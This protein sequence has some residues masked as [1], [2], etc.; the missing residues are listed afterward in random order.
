MLKGITKVGMS[1]TKE[2]QVKKLG[3]MLT[4]D[5]KDALD[6]TLDCLDIHMSGHLADKMTSGELS[7]DWSMVENMLEEK[8]IIE[9]NLNPNG[10][11]RAVLRNKKNEKVY[12]DG[13]QSSANLIF[14]VDLYDGTMVTAWYNYSYDHHRYADK[15]RYVNFDVIEQLD[16][17]YA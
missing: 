3:S 9:V 2:N 4:T 12:L 13:K 16:R 7:F 17:L 6:A 1:K 10:A 15:S 14:V 8:N 5:E 11:L